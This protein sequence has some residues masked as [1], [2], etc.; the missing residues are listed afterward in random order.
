[1]EFLEEV[2]ADGL[3]DDEALLA[4]HLADDVRGS[5]FWSMFNY[6]ETAV[7]PSIE[8]SEKLQAM[9][10]L[11]IAALRRALPEHLAQSS[12]SQYPS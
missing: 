8:E 3:L 6:F 4:F 7:N 1:M 11:G 9:F 12:E 10:E 5:F 2:E